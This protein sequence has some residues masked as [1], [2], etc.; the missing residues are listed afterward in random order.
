MW[1]VLLAILIMAGLIGFNLY[2]YYVREV[3]PYRAQ[4]RQQYGSIDV[5]HAK[6]LDDEA[7]IAEAAKILAGGET[8]ISPM[9]VSTK[10]R[11]AKRTAEFR[12]RIAAE[13]KQREAETQVKPSKKKRVAKKVSRGKA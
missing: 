12:D 6:R 3:V 9:P 4:R 2:D 5:E 7:L 11:V 8:S 13:A 10:T 1:I